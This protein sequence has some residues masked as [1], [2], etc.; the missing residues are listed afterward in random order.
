VQKADKNEKRGWAR[1]QINQMPSQDKHNASIKVA[2]QIINHEIFKSAEI[3]AAYVAL[4]D[5]LN[6]RPILE[7][8]LKQNKR[9]LLPFVDGDIMQFS[10]ISDLD[11]DL[12]KGNFGILEP[13]NKL[14][15]QWDNQ[16]C[17]IIIPARLFDSYGGRIGRGKGYYDKYL[18]NKYD[19]TK[20]GVCFDVQ[21]Y[22]K[23]LNLQHH[24]QIMD[25]IISE[26]Q[27]LK[28]T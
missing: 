21:I 15:F 1:I 2:N 27:F 12:A 3:I 24:D 26:K 7:E 23:K 11:Q 13:V 9:L 22:D 14:P 28:I 5:E 16:T 19:S 6:T 4:D 18:S 17:V 25:Y 8:A 20:V 10:A